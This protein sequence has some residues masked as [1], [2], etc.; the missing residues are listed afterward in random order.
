[1]KGGHSEKIMEMK[2]K[3]CLGGINRAS[4]G[5]SESLAKD[6]G[7]ENIEQASKLAGSAE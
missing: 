3:A 7:K 6:A 5:V 4:A 1:M 2:E